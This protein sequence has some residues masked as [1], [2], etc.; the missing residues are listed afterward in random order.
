M[1]IKSKLTFLFLTLSLLPL[2]SATLL[3]IFHSKNQTQE[4]SIAV[5]ESTVAILA[6]NLDNYFQLRQQ[7]INFLANSPSVTTM[8]FSKMR[9]YLI[10]EKERSK[11]IYEK[12]IIG[13]PNGTFYNTSGGNTLQGM[14]RTFNDSSAISK[15]KSIHQRDYWQNTIQTP[16]KNQSYVSN[17]MISYTTGVRQVVVA[18]SILDSTQAVIGMIGGALPWSQI[19]KLIKKNKASI[20][21]HFKNLIQFMLVSNNGTYMY[22]WNPNKVIQLRKDSLGNFIKNSIG[23]KESL[24]HNISSEPSGPLRKVAL[25]MLKGHSGYTLLKDPKTNQSQY[26]IFHPLKS[27]GYS[28]AVTLPTS[29]ITAPVK[30]LTQKLLLILLITVIAIIIIALITSSKLSSPI[31]L[32]SKTAKKI[33]E[34]KDITLANIQSFSE[35]MELAQSI[36]SMSQ[37]IQVRKDELENQVLLRT[38]ELQVQKIKAEKAS[39]SK[40]QFL[41]NMSHEIRTP[42]NGVLGILGL[43]L[44]TQL[45]PNQIKQINIA[46]SSAESLLTIINDILDYSK[47][48]ANK[49]EIENIDFNIFQIISQFAAP[50]GF[51]A[52]NKNLEL[53][54]DTVEVQNTEFLGDPSRY[55]QILTNIV[56]NAIKFTKKG[57]VSITLRSTPSKFNPCETLLI[58]EVTDTGIGIPNDK[59]DDL[60]NSFSQVDSSTTREYGGTGLGLSISQK[61]CTLMKG[62]I[63]VKSK[64][65]EGT[66]IEF[67]IYLQ[68]KATKTIAYK[69]PHLINQTVLIFEPT[70]NLAANLR[71]SLERW[72]AQV[73]LTQSIEELSKH[74]DAFASFDWTFISDN[75]SIKKHS[76]LNT[77]I[78]KIKNLIWIQSLSTTQKQSFDSKTIT[79]PLTD[80]DLSQ[81]F[82]RETL[83][84]VKPTL[85]KATQ[86]TTQNSHI[87]MVEDNETNQVI[88]AGIL[89]K[90][91]YKVTIANNGQEALDLLRQ[92]EPDSFSLIL[93]DCQMPILDGYQTTQAL[94]EGAAGAEYQLIPIIALTANAM[95]G[96]DNTCKE[97]GMN[98][99]LSK[100]IIPNLLSQL[101]QKWIQ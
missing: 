8:N 11:G 22:H 68:N 40:G 81:V 50:I 95:Q 7:E 75:E 76:F 21:N 100:P 42:M 70:V 80:F 10:S 58:T 36:Q 91:N 24:S 87:L 57:S 13:K 3:S 49:L 56:S 37:K 60:F 61:L 93:M 23:E 41:A 34:G 16:S 15:P 65:N 32:L 48:E 92:V 71:Q 99:Y 5:A 90:I 78:V 97:A 6:Q 54:F 33:G 26:L 72:G 98:D 62:N 55:R 101:L 47:I 73:T 30:S 12:F 1:K 28:V 96:D 2:F 31:T 85:L 38:Q 43:V 20:P 63:Q 94:R 44:D 67:S 25:K 59:L 18:S 84:K 77:E 19:E 14:L 29:I 39:E 53:L 9:N 82:F 52:E 83:T 86:K 46:K 4:L 35:I 88:L 45:D 64:L 27:A 79:S 89:K 69:A 66:K 17:P 51:Q 74:T